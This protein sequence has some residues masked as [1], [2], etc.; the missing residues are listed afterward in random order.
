[1]NKFLE[2][3]NIIAVLKNKKWSSVSTIIYINIVVRIE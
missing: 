3:T 1:M 2:H